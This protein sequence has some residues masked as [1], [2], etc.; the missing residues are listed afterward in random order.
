MPD[1]REVFEYPNQHWSLLTAPTD[2]DFEGQYF[3]RKEAGRVGQNGCVSSREMD[4]VVDQIAECIS[5]F[6]NKNMS[7]SLLVVGISTQ[8]EIK[9]ISHLSDSQR[10]RLTNFNQM[11]CNQAAQAKFFDCQ[12]DSGTPDKICLIY[13]PYAP[14]RIC[15]TVGNSPRAWIRQGSQNIP[16][17]DLSREQLKRDKKIVDFEQAYCCAYDQRDLDQAVLQEFRRLFLS[18]SHYEY[19]D[20]DL[21]YQI[22]ALERDGAGYTFTNAGLLFFCFKSAESHASIL[23]SVAAL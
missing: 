19:N 10:S 18:E 1:P 22:G 14:Q 8:G 3:D 17:N 16:L 21:L 2:T 9:G 13:V 15:E 4:N 11:L 12:N 5:A 7:G 6:A 20:E 23:H